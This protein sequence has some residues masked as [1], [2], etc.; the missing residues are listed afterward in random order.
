MKINLAILEARQAMDLSQPQ[1]ANRAGMTRSYISKIETSFVVPSIPTFVRLASALNIN[2]CRLLQRALDP[3]LNDSC[4]R[5]R[6]VIMRNGRKRVMP[7]REPRRGKIQPLSF[8]EGNL[9]HDPTSVAYRR[10]LGRLIA[11]VTTPA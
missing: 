3:S 1:L 5:R 6:S 9:V 10:E 7:V 4:V 8:P 2:P 11:G